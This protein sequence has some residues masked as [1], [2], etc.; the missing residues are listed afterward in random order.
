MLV[1]AVPGVALIVVAA[2]GVWLTVPQAATDC[3]VIGALDA[4]ARPPVADPTAPP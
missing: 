1:I 4:G 2:V 3:P